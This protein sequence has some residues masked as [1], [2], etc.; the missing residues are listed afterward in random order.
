MKAIKPIKEG[1]EIFNDYG[2]IPRSDLLRRYGYVTE[3]YAPYDVIELPLDAICEAAGLESADVESQ[4]AVCCSC[5]V[6]VVLWKANLTQ[7][8]FL[9]DLELL[10]DGYAIPR[11]S[12][13]DSLSDIL[14][15]E[16]LLLL[17]TLAFS[18]EQL[19]QQ[20]S[21][22]KPP[23]PSLG[24]T[25]A[26]ILF[27]AVQLKQSQYATTISQDQEHLARFGQ[28]VASERSSRRQKMAT[29]VRIGEKEVLH[30]LSSML[31]GF[32]TDGD[33]SALKRNANNDGSDSRKTKAQKN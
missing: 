23:K 17:K 13:E 10:D 20:K 8:H 9:E 11:P 19:K 28:L 24:Q 31:D 30:K 7:L 33:G 22:N 12:P 16:L 27:K 5:P 1:D 32:I 25:E 14:P 26:A 6:Y 18:P 4:P 21:K 3:N 29:Q 2:E 15:D